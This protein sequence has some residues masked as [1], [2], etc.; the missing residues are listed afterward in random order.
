ME[1]IRV[2]KEIITLAMEI[3]MSEMADHKKRYGYSSCKKRL[4][5]IRKVACQHK[6]NGFSQCIR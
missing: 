5:I 1:I 4:V 3:I 6:N 2:K